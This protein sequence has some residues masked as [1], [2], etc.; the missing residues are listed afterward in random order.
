MA[1]LRINKALDS[2]KTE[3][4]FGKDDPFFPNEFP[5]HSAGIAN[6]PQVLEEVR[7]S[8]YVA[9]HTPQLQDLQNPVYDYRSQAD[10]EF[11]EDLKD[12]YLKA[13]QK[14]FI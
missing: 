5:E 6:N 8:V 2:T 11:K 3:S 7:K 13:K 4:V 10:M 12:K 9:K 1:S 14:H